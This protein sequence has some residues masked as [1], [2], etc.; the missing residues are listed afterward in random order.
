VLKELALGGK[1]RGEGNDNARGFF[2]IVME[3]KSL[4]GQ[5]GIDILNLLPSDQ[6]HLL[7]GAKQRENFD[8]ER[9]ED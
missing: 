5:I 6:R 8:A 1:D 9:R 3:R 4:A 7:F 2:D